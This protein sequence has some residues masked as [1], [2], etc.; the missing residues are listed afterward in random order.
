MPYG[1][2]VIYRY[3]GTF[4]GLMCCVFESFEKRE[5]PEE[6]TASPEQM[7]FYETKDI[8]T[9]YEKASRVSKGIKEKISKNAYETV[10]K[11]FLTCHEQKEVLILKF[12]HLG[13]KYGKNVM[14][15]LADDTV[16]ELFK[17]V[18]HL[19]RELHLFLGFVRFSSYDG[20]LVSVIEPKN[21][22]LP[23]MKNHFCNRLPQ[24]TFM[25]FDKTNHMA[26]VYRPY[27]AQIIP[28][29]ELSLPCANEEELHYRRLWKKFY[30]TI[31]IKERY[32][33][34]CRMTMM[35]KRYWKHMTEFAELF[36]QNWEECK[37]FD[38]APDLKLIE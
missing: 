9:D 28:V 37:K 22:I 19:E 1:T 34:K 25:I 12:L 10:C 5:I 26:L 23:L 38:S 20:V 3:D 14:N 24:E 27:E 15:M 30:D 33:P 17:A 11:A 2:N 18:R 29:E 31:G 13:F 7:S 6:I 16:N 36:P 32:N 21:I 8:L 4:D 35:P